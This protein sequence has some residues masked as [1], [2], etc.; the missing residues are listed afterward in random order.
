LSTKTDELPEPGSL[1]E[2]ELKVKAKAYYTPDCKECKWLTINENQ[3]LIPEILSWKVIPGELKYG[4]YQN[5]DNKKENNYK[6]LD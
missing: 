5:L 3:K 4:P 6:E 1:C 2:V